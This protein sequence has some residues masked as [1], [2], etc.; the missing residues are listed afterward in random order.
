M[1]NTPCSVFIKTILKN[2]A[3]T[4]K[5]RPDRREIIHKPTRQPYR[6][7]PNKNGIGDNNPVEYFFTK[8]DCRRFAYG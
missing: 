2:K 1:P 6:N 7:C 4:N 8:K 3:D 5:S